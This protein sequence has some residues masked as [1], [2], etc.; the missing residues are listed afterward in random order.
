MN[1]ISDLLRNT[2]TCFGMLVWP[3]AV[4]LFQECSVF[5]LSSMDVLPEL[6]GLARLS[7]FG[8]PHT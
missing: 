1:C 4:L 7:P 8:Q 5:L 2:L 6:P 3:F